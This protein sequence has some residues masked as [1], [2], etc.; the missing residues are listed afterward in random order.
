M[1]GYTAASGGDSASAHVGVTDARL[2]LRATS[3]L[4]F[5]PSDSDTFI[6]TG[7]GT[8]VIQGWSFTPDVPEGVS[9]SVREGETWGSCTSPVATCTNLV[10]RS[11]TVMVVGTVRG[12]QKTATVHVQVVP[13]LIR[14][15]AS[16]RALAAGDSATFT[17]IANGTPLFIQGWTFRAD[18]TPDRGT[19]LGSSWGTCVP[20][21]TQ[22]T[23]VVPTSG[24]VLVTGTIASYPSSD[25]V[26]V[27]VMSAVSAARQPRAQLSAA[28]RLA[29]DLPETESLRLA[30]QDWIVRIRAR[31]TRPAKRASINAQPTPRCVRHRRCI[32][33]RPGLATTR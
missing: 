7:N 19:I 4:L 11:G 23:M 6:A 18:G 13:P 26:H 2:R 20:N 5:A 25:S 15:A 29:L 22:C 28:R 30:A 1:W 9:S 31:S 10:T 24:M 12:T 14:L 3:T 16:K 21:T 32:R 17:A 8:T 33:I 27:T